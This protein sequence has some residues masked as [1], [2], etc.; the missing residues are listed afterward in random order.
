MMDAIV[1][2]FDVGE[3]VLRSMGIRWSTDIPTPGFPHTDAS[4]HC[5]K[6]KDDFDWSTLGEFYLRQIGAMVGKT[7]QPKP[8]LRCQI[9]IRAPRAPR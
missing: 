1:Y 3:E 6:F 5:G 8:T 2:G 4:D 7:L 9:N